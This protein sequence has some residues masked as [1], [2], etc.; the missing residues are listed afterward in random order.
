MPL[1]VVVTRDVEPR[2]RGFLG[3]VLLEVAPGVYVGPR[4]SKAVRERIWAVVSEWHETLLRGS[5]LMLWREA[6]APGGVQITMRGDPP[7]DLCE[8]DETLLVRR[9][10]R[11]ED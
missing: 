9:P 5:V 8:V 2:Y 10:V 6:G 1:C 4:T 11:R 3:S 7:K